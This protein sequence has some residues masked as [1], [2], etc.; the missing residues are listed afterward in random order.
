[1][2][3]EPAGEVPGSRPARDRDAEDQGPRV[4]H[5]GP[6]AAVGRWA[7]RRC[8]SGRRSGSTAR[9]SSRA[10]SRSRIG[11]SA[12]RT[13]SRARTTRRRASRR[14]SRTRSTPR[15]SSTASARCG[16]ASSCAPTRSSRLACYKVYNDWIADFQAYAPE[17]FICNGTLPTTGLDDA[18]R[19]AAPLRRAR[20]ADGAARV[21]SEWVVHRPV[22]GRRPVLGRGGR[23]RHADQRAHPVLLPGRRPRLED[24]R[25][26]RANGQERAK[27]LGLD[28]QAGSFPV[29][30]WRDDRSR[31]CSS[32]SRI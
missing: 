3:R 12:T 10:S 31:A 14:S 21:V 2:G 15:S 23:A 17:R 5:G 29:I 18:H 28:V 22:A 8:T 24:H 1:M 26:G 16:T 11:A 25:R 32:A 19:R 30:L 6:D 27:K 13:C 7:S 4:D 20:P 9:R